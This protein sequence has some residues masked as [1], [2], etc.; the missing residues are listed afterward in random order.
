M[1]KVSGGG[2]GVGK[3]VDAPSRRDKFGRGLST[4][5]ELPARSLSVL[6][7]DGSYMI[8]FFNIMLVSAIQQVPRLDLAT[9][10]EIFFA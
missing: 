4:S 9:V 7:F 2:G 3:G 6:T 10:C 8:A 5:K 1:A